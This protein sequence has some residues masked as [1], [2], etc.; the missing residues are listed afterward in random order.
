M[1]SRLTGSE[2]GLVGYWRFAEGS[3]TTAA[4]STSYNHPLTFNGSTGWSNDLPVQ[5][6][7]NFE[8]DSTGVMATGWSQFGGA[9]ITVETPLTA[10]KVLQRLAG[11]GNQSDRARW[12]ATANFNNVEFTGDFY[13]PTTLCDPTVM[14]RTTGTGASPTGYQTVFDFINGVIST[15][16]V[17]NGSDTLLNQTSKALGNAQWWHFRV[18]QFNSTMYIRVWNGS[19]EPGTWDVVLTNSDI[20]GSGAI[21]LGVYID[22]TVYWDN[23]AVV[24]WSP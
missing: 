13:V 3:G 1:Y 24:S 20:T 16:K 8:A 17:V 18:R 10:N 21:A 7:D 2:S 11:G 4:D 15:H 5:F 6:T 22:A 9:H 23:I 14:W 12:D 19:T